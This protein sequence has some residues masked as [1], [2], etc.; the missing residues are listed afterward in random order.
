[1]F[2]PITLEKLPDF[3]SYF[4]H[5]PFRMSDY[6]AGF[7]LMWMDYASME[8]AETDG[9]LI[10]RTRYGGRDRFCYPLSPT[11]NEADEIRALEKLEAWCLINEK[12]LCLLA[13]PEER[14]LLLMRR[15]GRSLQVINPRTWRDYLYRFDDFADY[16]GRR[17]SGQRNHVS[18]FNRT[19]PHAA[20]R[21]MTPADMEDVR[22]FLRVYAERQYAKHSFMAN[23]EL[24]GT[25]VLLS[26]FE[27]LHMVGGIM[28][29]EGTVAAVTI[30]E[31]AGDTLIVH[32]EK[33]LVGYEGIYPTVA[34]AFARALR[35]PGLDYINREDDAGDCGLRKSKLQYNPIR[36]IDKYNIM[37]KRI[38]EE[39]ESVPEITSQRLVLRA[40]PD[41]DVH[42]FGRLARD[43]ERNRLWGWDWRTAWKEEADPRDTWF[44]DNTRRDFAS[45]HEI[46]LG[47]YAD[48]TFVGECVFH[49]FTYDHT[50]ELGVRLL[51]EYEHNGYATEAMRTMAD[52]ALCFWGLEKACAKCYHENAASRAMLT[53]SGLRS[54]HEDTTFAYFARTAKN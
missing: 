4:E 30:G 49:N 20:F 27:A 34:Q 8:Y 46:S 16:A 32:V 5:Q 23:E 31:I 47:I 33:A 53:A 40:I 7:Q 28:E 44:L 37:P 43:V 18:R 11:A 42:A 39:L 48:G 3:L 22:A 25:E 50:V 36:L 26:H 12:Q 1:M 17:F 15:Y 29:V 54:T 41:E 10:I 38:I 9:C 13:I 45:H 6:T 35:R 52:Y 51:P 14:I 24:H 21:L 19:Y 2:S